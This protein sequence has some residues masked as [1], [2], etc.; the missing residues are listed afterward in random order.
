MQPNRP[1]LPCVL[2]A[3]FEHPPPA[4]H[5]TAAL[6]P[7]A[8]LTAENS[9]DAS[10]IA[11]HT[12]RRNRLNNW[13]HAE[14]ETP[15]LSNGCSP[16][17]LRR[18]SLSHRLC[19]IFRGEKRWAVWR[20]ECCR[21]TT[22]QYPPGSKSLKLVFARATSLPACARRCF[23]SRIEGTHKLTNRLSGNKVHHMRG[24]RTPRLR[25]SHQRRA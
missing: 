5:P 14:E 9:C 23:I 16:L 17:H 25:D 13:L 10:K 4:A 15:L 24:G 12:A 20:Y 6:D 7:P 18:R 21:R 11:E 1:R 19:H 22:W 2:T 8:D 3:P